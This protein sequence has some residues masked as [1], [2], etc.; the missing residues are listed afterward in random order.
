VPRDRI[1]RLFVDRERVLWHRIDED[2]FTALRLDRRRLARILVEAV[3]PVVELRLEVPEVRD[4]VGHEVPDRVRLFPRVGGTDVLVSGRG[5]PPAE[6][7]SRERRGERLVVRDRLAVDVDVLDDR[8][9][10]TVPVV[11]DVVD[12][13]LRLRAEVRAGQNRH[14]LLQRRLQLSA[15]DL[16]LHRRVR[17]REDLVHV[18]SLQRTALVDPVRPDAAAVL[19]R[20]LGV[21]LL[22]HRLGD[23]VPEL[24]FQVVVRVE[25]RV[26][27]LPRVRDLLR[28]LLV[29]DRVVLL[30]YRGHRVVLLQLRL[31]EGVE[32]A[33]GDP[34]VGVERQRREVV[35]LVAG[36]RDGRPLDLLDLL[37]DRRVVVAD[38]RVEA[39]DVPGQRPLRRLASQVRPRHDEVDPFL[40]TEVI[41]RGLRRLDEVEAGPSLGCPAR[42]NEA[43]EAD[44]HPPDVGRHPLFRLRVRALAVL[45]GEV[46]RQPRE[47][48]VREQLHHPISTEVALVVPDGDPVRIHLVERFEDVLPLEP[49]PG[50]RRRE[51]VPSTHEQ[52]VLVFRLELLDQP[53][54]LRDVGD[55]VLEAPVE[56]RVVD[57]GHRL[58]VLCGGAS[59][60]PG[61]ER[62]ER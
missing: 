33:V 31:R 12:L 62:A 30:A 32:R 46:R 61:P 17:E 57:H 9:L 26:E 54:V 27:V 44:R 24:V 10:D 28:E 5:L 23:E 45:S 1:E 52:R 38:D 39:V 25:P 7:R 18:A 58:P 6:V 35:V 22:G 3:D 37:G 42:G 41:D 8:L 40:L 50:E 2:D 4:V 21:R 60:A 11:V 15:G 13:Y 14:G 43:E 36:Q 34:A 49:R 51:L 16:K 55:V 56:V 20:N 47:L 48:A 53:P 59:D 29:E 19:D